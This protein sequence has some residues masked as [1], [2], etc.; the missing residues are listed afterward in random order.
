MLIT[1]QT[2]MKDLPIIEQQS[3]KPKAAILSHT[4]LLVGELTNALQT[5]QIETQLIFLPSALGDLSRSSLTHQHAKVSSI[6]QVK[7]QGI[8]YLF[9]LYPSLGAISPHEY[10]RFFYNTPPQSKIIIIDNFRN[11]AKT[12]QL[13]TYL[14]N[15]NFRVALLT[16]IF[17][18]LTT[19]Q[20]TNPA[21]SHISQALN[22]QA[23]ELMDTGQT[24]LY[25]T[26][27]Q[28]VVKGIIKAIFSGNTQS[29]SY[30]LS[31]L[32]PIS[33]LSFSQHL[34]THS[35]EILDHTPPI[36][37]ISPA[38]NP[39]VLPD[40]DQI[41]ATQ[42]QLN[43]SPD[44]DLDIAISQTLAISHEVYSPPI[45]ESLTQETR[46]PLSSTPNQSVQS[47]QVNDIPP[48]PSLTKP[49]N[50]F[51][52]AKK[53][54][55]KKRKKALLLFLSV[56][57][58]VFLLPLISLYITITQGI[59]QFSQSY[60][61]LEQG[62][63]QQSQTAAQKSKS[64]F[65]RARVTLGITKKLIPLFP[66]TKYDKY[67]QQ[68]DIAVR[69]SDILS[70]TSTTLVKADQ[71]YSIITNTNTGNFHSANSDLKVSLDSLYQHLSLVQASVDQVDFNSNLFAYDKLKTAKDN[72]P[73]MRKTTEQALKLVSILPD[74][75]AQEQPQTHLLLL[76]NNLEL[77]P[78]G[79]LVAVAGLLTFTNG[80]LTNFQTYN[81][82]TLDSQLDGIVTPPPD[83]ATYLGEDRWFLRDS[84]WSAH[85]P[86]SALQAQWF[87]DKMLNRPINGVVAVDLYAL[88]EL[89]KATG[90]VLIPEQTNPIT[91]DNLLE[92]IQFGNQDNESDSQQTQLLL[93][94]ANSIISKL[95]EKQI[96]LITLSTVL[97]K[98]LSENH[99]LIYSD[100]PSIQSMLSTYNWDG[101]INNPSCPSRFN[102]QNCT[103]QTFSLIEANVGINQ[104][105]YYLDRRFNHQ[106]N[107]G[108]QGQI[109]HTITI[110][111]TNNSPN[112]SWPGGKYKTFT[113]IYT[114]LHSQLISTNFAGQEIQP[115]RITPNLELGLQEIAYIYEIS[116]QTE[117]SLIISLR[118][119]QIFNLTQLP[120]TL[121]VN[122]EKQ[123]GTNKDPVS[124]TFNY[125]Q[126]L[127]PRQIS[128]PATTQNQQTI[129]HNQLLQDT[130]F[131]IQF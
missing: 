72:L 19:P 50:Y 53:P 80:R 54:K 78:A 40:P 10:E 109:D 66:K 128:Q 22:N 121:A 38:P 91:S 59:S 93:S 129:F 94:L 107:I 126:N 119:S 123:P 110:D 120:G 130:I 29:Q 62:R 42:A 65:I 117:S 97:T 99:L 41:I 21:L 13:I 37:Y 73:E 47:D 28:D 7:T 79:G 100:Q 90:P 101:S 86:S 96:H 9:Y 108:Q 2:T 34:K 124:V 11:Q 46:P 27:S 36:E 15:H 14:R 63:Y 26:Y 116:P 20:Y 3:Q 31:T 61:Y 113:R 16:D 33:E 56:V 32:E 81:V 70:L 51:D 6:T 12:D 57:L 111:Y 71:L 104:S 83:I 98:S 76:Q 115:V 17:G 45:N 48:K 39:P 67:D 114:P 64:S 23:L 30:L 74:L 8:D 44:T 87:I 75:I 82:P 95:Q 69:L 85:F 1:D 102:Q 49:P 125:P 5:Q 112:N 60:A 84:N 105:N 131:A 103:T 118:S 25:P 35:A 58:I 18:P 68:L 43:W 122:W 88:Q 89:I 4:S 52:L 24:P 77:R 106:V 55:T 92:N 127:T